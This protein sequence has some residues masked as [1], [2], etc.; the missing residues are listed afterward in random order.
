MQASPLDDECETEGAVVCHQGRIKGQPGVALDDLVYI[1]TK[2]ARQM[3]SQVKTCT[4]ASAVSSW[5]SRA[6]YGA[7]CRISVLY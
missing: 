2:I 6:V 3:D 5:D 1:C 4:S 7:L